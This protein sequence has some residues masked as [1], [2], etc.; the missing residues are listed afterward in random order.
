MNL[1]LTWSRRWRR[2]DAVPIDAVFMI[3]WESTEGMFTTR[4]FDAGFGYLWGGGLGDYAWPPKPKEELPAETDAERRQ[5]KRIKQLLAANARP[6]NDPVA[7]VGD[8]VI[9]GVDRGFL[10]AV[11]LDVDGGTQRA[12]KVHQTFDSNCAAC[13]RGSWYRS[14]TGHNCAWGLSIGGWR[15]E[16]DYS[17]CVRYDDEDLS[18]EEDVDEGRVRLR[19]PEPQEARARPRPV[20]LGQPTDD[21]HADDADFNTGQSARSRRYEARTGEVE[22][23]EDEEAGA[24]SGRVVPLD[25]FTWTPTRRNCELTA[26]NLDPADPELVPRSLADAKLYLDRALDEPLYVLLFRPQYK[27]N[28][29]TPDYSVLHSLERATNVTL[30][31]GT[32]KLLQ[33]HLR[34]YNLDW[35][36]KHFPSD[37]SCDMDWLDHTWKRVYVH[38]RLDG[39]KITLR[40]RLPGETQLNI[41]LTNLELIAEHGLW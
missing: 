36:K 26:I 23:D 27:D 25:E 30:R 11:V 1:N 21:N 18:D 6:V 9:I 7:N 28:T 2:R 8:D 40:G 20:Y 16:T 38:D 5:R 39:Y 22:D 24:F 31:K 17:Y 19:S 41:H 14:E 35:Y 4:P 13:V 12:V 37:E 10:R 34:S 15:L 29:G 33:R 3:T 32:F